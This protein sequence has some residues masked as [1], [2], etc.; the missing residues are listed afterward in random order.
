[1]VESQATFAD[2]DEKS[3]KKYLVISKEKGRLSNFSA[4]ISMYWI[5]FGKGDFLKS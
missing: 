5:M 4:S 1:V 2:I 3:V